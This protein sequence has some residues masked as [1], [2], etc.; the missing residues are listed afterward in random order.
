M[1]PLDEETRAKRAISDLIFAY[2]QTYGL[3]DHPLSF[4]EFADLLNEIL[5]PHDIHLSKQ[6]IKNWED[7]TSLPRVLY[8]LHISM[9]AFDWRRDLAED[10]LAALRPNLYKPATYIGMRAI[11]RSLIDTGPQKPR[12]D[13]YFT[14]QPWHRP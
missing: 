6:S 7:R 2:R 14:S 3:E 8:P 11:D 1:N 12:Y 9:D 10:M 13:P 4:R 5:E